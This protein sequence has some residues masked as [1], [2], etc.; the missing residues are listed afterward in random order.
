M[1]VEQSDKTEFVRLL[2][3]NNIQIGPI[4]GFLDAQIVASVTFFIR[5]AEPSALSY[6]A[7]V[8]EA[9]ADLFP[10]PHDLLAISLNERTI[11][12]VITPRSGQALDPVHIHAL[13]QAFR[14]A[15]SGVSEVSRIGEPEIIPLAY[16]SPVSGIQE[17]LAALNE[18][19][20]TIVNKRLRVQFQPIVDLACGRVHGYESLIRLPQDGSLKR[21]GTLFRMADAARL[22]SWVDIAYQETCFETSVREGL[23]EYLFVNMDADGLAHLDLA[24]ASLADRAREC[25][26]DPRLV[27]MEITE[28][29]E[30]G[31]F[32]QLIQYI[33][34]LR[35]QGFRVAID[36]AGA[37]YNSLHAIAQIRP[38][39]LKI[40]R[41]LVRGLNVNMT[42][43]ALI[44]SL[45]FFGGRIGTEVIAEGIETM[46]ELAAVV[47]CGVRYGQGYLLGK[48]NDDFRGVRK[49]IRE[50]L[51]S[52]FSLRSKRGLGRSYPIKSLV[53][54][55][56]VMPPETPVAEIRRKFERNHDVE[57]IVLCSDDRIDGTI[58]RD[59]IFEIPEGGL[60]RPIAKYM[61]KNPVVV[62]AMLPIEEA[63]N[64]C[65]YLLNGK[66]SGHLVVSQNGIYAGE[67]PIRELVRAVATLCAKLTQ[68]SRA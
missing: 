67:V 61:D 11:A 4:D 3:G 32:P 62:E 14:R 68:T 17:N 21:A 20:E 33:N 51:A 12:A 66:P 50:E 27:V 16:I 49:T 41:S 5:F 9:L 46:D 63:A 54:R 64:Q 52:Q 39:F 2:A 22:V 65:A 44:E 43:R 42:H 19:L 55:G 26:I 35:S 58:T 37:G 48:P 53:Q 56:I 25:G 15:L 10:E 8:R 57:C 6:A 34:D 28:R 31:E 18:M 7:I 13:E 1:Y 24:D 59:T 40:E 29:Q 38:D 30:V 23:R 45:A 60:E 47:D 36:D